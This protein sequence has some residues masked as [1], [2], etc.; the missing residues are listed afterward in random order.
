MLVTSEGKAY[1]CPW[2]GLKIVFRVTFEVSSSL[3]SVLNGA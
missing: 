1:Q 2:L 3:I